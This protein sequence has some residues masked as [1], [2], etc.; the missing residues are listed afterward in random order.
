VNPYGSIAR[1]SQDMHP[2]M[3]ELILW[4]RDL[5]LGYLK[6][7]PLVQYISAE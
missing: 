7:P 2:D 1:S 3:A 5:S 6:H 4:S